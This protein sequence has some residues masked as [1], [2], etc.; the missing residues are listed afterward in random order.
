MSTHKL[1][2]LTIIAAIL[3]VM[4]TV[5]LSFDR[6]VIFAFS[7][8]YGLS[9]SY[10]SLSKNIVNGYSF[11]NLKILNKPIGFGFFS[12]KANLKINNKTS[13]L[14]SLDIDFKFRDVHFIRSKPENTKGFYDSLNK[15][16]TV[17]FEGR[18]MYKDVS[19]TVEIFSNGLTLRNLAA[20]SN[21]IRLALSG[22]MF[23]S[24][25][26]N[27]DITVYFSKEVLKDIPPE[28]HS[29]IMNDEPKEWKSFSVKMK[30]DTNAPSL[31]V[32]GKLFRLNIGTAVV[33]E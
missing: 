2:V 28:L 10:T 6:I 33:S 9:I 23:Y 17:P 12:A 8:I 26:L 18:W 27:M 32:S 29:V 1:K 20:N 14:K 24:N 13:L 7:K 15:L 4:I 19:G 5:Y 21:D 30:G 3:A 31:Q 25:K 16:V 11:E 22:D